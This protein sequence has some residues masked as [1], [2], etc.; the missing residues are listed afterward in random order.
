MLWSGFS[1][2]RWSDVLIHLSASWYIHVTSHSTLSFNACKAVV[3]EAP[4]GKAMG[5]SK[6]VGRGDDV[7]KRNK[8]NIGSS[9][10]ASWHY[11]RTSTVA[12]ISYSLSDVQSRSTSVGQLTSLLNL[13]A[14]PFA[15]RWYSVVVRCFVPKM[16]IAT[17]KPA[18]NVSSIVCQIVLRGS[19]TNYAVVQE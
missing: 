19:E 3:T 13:S 16:A 9:I 7:F 14:Y 15:L 8:M 17:Q 18:G 11:M 12:R 1:L 5:L 2:Y 4:V 10:F 6:I